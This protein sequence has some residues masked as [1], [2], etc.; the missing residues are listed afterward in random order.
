MPSRMA[1]TLDVDRTPRH[2]GFYPE[3]TPVP[4]AR[5]RLLAA[6]RMRPASLAEVEA[7]KAD[8]R[9]AAAY[10]PQRNAPAPPDLAAALAARPRAAR[11]FGALGR[12]RRYAV[13]LK[14]LTA[15]TPSARAAQLGRALTALEGQAARLKARRQR[16]VRRDGVCALMGPLVVIRG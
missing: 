6:G 7:A 11:A 16:P 15:R 10:E 1:T 5:A 14:L 13:I 3:H 2:R 12:T 9:W 4:E 8:G